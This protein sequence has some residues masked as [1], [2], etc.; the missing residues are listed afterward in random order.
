MKVRESGM[1]EEPMW[2]T[3][4]DADQSQA[5]FDVVVPFVSLPPHHD[6]VVGQK[7]SET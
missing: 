1:P 6:G 4:F 5:G 3:F 2:A 7:P